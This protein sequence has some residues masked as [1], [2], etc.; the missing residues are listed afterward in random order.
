MFSP[1]RS[2][3]RGAYHCLP[4][5]WLDETAIASYRHPLTTQLD[6]RLDGNFS[7][8]P[9]SDAGG[10]ASGNAALIDKPGAQ[11]PARHLRQPAINVGAVTIDSR[12]NNL[13][14]AF[15]L[16]TMR[17][18]SRASASFSQVR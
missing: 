6:H 9:F 10:R 7:L 13:V 17:H 18:V 14:D 4:E 3:E 16:H 8:G 11:F 12:H 15:H 2:P 5:K 1:R